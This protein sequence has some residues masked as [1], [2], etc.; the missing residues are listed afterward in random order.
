MGRDIIEE[1]GSLALATRLK[2]LSERLAKDVS[3]V[4]KESSLAFEPR[5]FT[6]VYALKEGEELSVTALSTMLKQTHP[7]VNQVANVLVSNG[8]LQE[9]KDDADQRK[10]LLKLTDKGHALV[11]KM[12]DLW[13]QIKKAN[14]QLVSESGG[15]LLK[16][17]DK[18]ES[19][20][21]EKSMYERVRS[22]Q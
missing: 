7:A 12:T 10:R 9:S 6:L 5:W 18:V 4:Y 13:G 8:I 21:D 2:N 19:A 14:D 15:D 3:Q 1:L 16:N 22:L 17:L 20:L 11:A